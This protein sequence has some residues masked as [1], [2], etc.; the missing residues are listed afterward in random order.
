MSTNEAARP[1][2]AP[3]SNRK[4]SVAFIPRA[5]LSHTTLDLESI[6]DM[7]N[8]DEEA[9]LA[10]APKLSRDGTDANASKLLSLQNAAAVLQPKPLTSL[11]I[12]ADIVADDFPQ[13]KSPSPMLQAS[14]LVAA[15]AAIVAVE[16]IAAKS[17]KPA[18]ADAARDRKSSVRP[19]Q[20]KAD[21]GIAVTSFD[22]AA[23]QKNQA[24]TDELLKAMQDSEAGW[25]VASARVSE[26]AMVVQGDSERC[27]PFE[28][29]GS[30]ARPTSQATAAY[31]ELNKRMPVNSTSCSSTKAFRF[32][33]PPIAPI[34]DVQYAREGGGTVWT[35]P[36]AANAHAQHE[37]EQGHNFFK[38]PVHTDSSKSAIEMERREAA[39]AAM[40]DRAGYL[41]SEQTSAKPQSKLRNATERI[42]KHIR[43]LRRDSGG[44]VHAVSP[45][46][47]MRSIQRAVALEAEQQFASGATASVGVVVSDSSDESDSEHSALAFLSEPHSP[48]HTSSIQG[49]SELSGSLSPRTRQEVRDWASTATT[50][51]EH[52]SRCLHNCDELQL[53]FMCMRKFWA[54]ALEQQVSAGSARSPTSSQVE[55]PCCFQLKDTWLAELQAVTKLNLTQLLQRPEAISTRMVASLMTVGKARAGEKLKGTLE[56]SLAST[57]EAPKLLAQWTSIRADILASTNAQLS[58][59]R[60]S[61]CSSSVELQRVQWLVTATSDPDGRINDAT[62][63]RQL[64][65]LQLDK[66][67]VECLQQP[68]VKLIFSGG[69]QAEQLDFK[70][71][72][73]TREFRT[74]L[75]NETIA[76][77]H[78]L[79][80]AQSA[81]RQLE[82]DVS[83]AKASVH[84]SKEK[85]RTARQDA[86]ELL[87][88]ARHTCK[89][90]DA[91]TAQTV[92]AAITKLATCLPQEFAKGARLGQL[93][94]LLLSTDSSDGDISE[95]MAKARGDAIREAKRKAK[96]CIQQ[97]YAPKLQLAVERTEGTLAELKLRAAADEEQLRANSELRWEHDQSA[98]LTQA[99]ELKR[100]ITTLSERCK[101]VGARESKLRA[102]VSDVCELEMLKATLAVRLFTQLS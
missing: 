35:P 14:L 5:A 46:R 92:Q 9:P 80:V 98:L 8:S 63:E 73:L 78:K 83:R 59:V 86:S 97:T 100:D 77:V 16:S 68:G 60:D 30:P 26:W 61:L 79:Q 1:T 76:T 45:A 15:P 20:S 93:Q 38:P 50:I 74:S 62:K 99:T 44:S 28:P 4:E 82:A 52:A 42:V 41:A 12:L 17:S 37:A 72:Y 47:V 55:G 65:M 40:N 39:M 29:A 36:E 71:K 56:A 24:A 19:R 66:A 2:F 25:R 67:A 43:R 88:K 87:R 27:R 89:V 48:V 81:T 3:R 94:Q 64:C 54:D 49:H 33:S 58:C 91:D 23:S 7:D 102:L 10:F 85:L 13:I 96:D 69:L 22:L 32:S 34:L 84:A 18:A 57:Q 6:A 95:P 70:L 90:A 75:Q 101:A 53:G 51:S 31:E 21:V 11:E